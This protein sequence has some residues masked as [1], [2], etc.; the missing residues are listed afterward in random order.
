VP[1]AAVCEQLRALAT[2]ADR[3]IGDFR[4]NEG[5]PYF[6]ARDALAAAERARVARDRA[7]AL[8]AEVSADSEALAPRA[9]LV[10]ACRDW[11]GLNGYQLVAT[12]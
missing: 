10:K 11:A 7:T 9:R 12:A 2:P 6:R 8:R 5:D 3:L 4:P 1:L